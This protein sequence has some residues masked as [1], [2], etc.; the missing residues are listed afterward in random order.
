M[1][2]KSEEDKIFTE[3]LREN[4]IIMGNSVTDLTIYEP[5]R[6]TLDFQ[7]YLLR[8][9]F[10]KLCDTFKQSITEMFGRAYR[11]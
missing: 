7:S 2:Q 8:R 9:T 4:G 5:L 3:Y 11:K 6:N 1:I 10:R